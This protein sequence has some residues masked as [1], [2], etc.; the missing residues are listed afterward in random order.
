VRGET[1]EDR[2]IRYPFASPM[3]EMGAVRIRRARICKLT[4]HWPV[5]LRL[6]AE[7]MPPGDEQNG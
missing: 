7:L 1:G 4:H 6:D 5:P 3:R 2:A